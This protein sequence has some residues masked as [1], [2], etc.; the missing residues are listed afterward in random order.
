MSSQ[1]MAGS[2]RYGKFVLNVL[3]KLPKELPK[4]CCDDLT[5]AVQAIKSFL[6]RPAEAELKKHIPIWQ[7]LGKSASKLDS[8]H[9]EI[10]DQFDT[11]NAL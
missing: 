1:E 6:K 4:N 2:T 9:I 7:C 3:K 10:I 11:I 8:L 5:Q